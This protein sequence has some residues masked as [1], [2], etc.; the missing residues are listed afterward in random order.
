MAKVDSLD[1]AYFSRR[2]EEK[3]TKK[4]TPAGRK[5]FSSILQRAGEGEPLF[6][7]LAGEGGRGESLE[8]L[9]DEVHSSGGELLEAQSLENIKRYRR[10]VQGFLRH[11]VRKCM[12]VEQKSSGANVL[13][14]KRFT[15]IKVIDQKLEQ[16]VAQ[17]L[18]QQQR[19]LDILE[20]INEI[21][22]LLIDLLT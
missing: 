22:G 21:N 20:K 4:K 19:Q 2:S 11:V 16:L 7:D 5:L 18:Q 12:A 1:A 17:L 13:K 10:A 15:Q 3:K 9:L 6:A 8:A 14:R